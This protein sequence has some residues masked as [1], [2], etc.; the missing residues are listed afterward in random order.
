MIDGYTLYYRD[1]EDTTKREWFIADRL[2]VRFYDFCVKEAKVILEYD[3]AKWHP[4]QEQVH[5]FG[6]ELMEVTNISYKEKYAIDAAK[7]SKAEEKGFTVY[8]IRS[9]Y[10]QTQV[11]AIIE[12]FIDQVRKNGRVE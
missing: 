2:G 3:G 12:K 1:S 8:T 7:R 6:D 10:T 9:D 11:K 4:T 5:E